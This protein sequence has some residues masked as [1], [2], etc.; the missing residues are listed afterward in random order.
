MTPEAAM[1]LA[2]AQ[3]RRSRGRTHPNPPVGA[4]VYRGDR[5]LGR[6]RTRP[7]GGP[8][9]EVVAIEAALRRHGARALRGASLAV[10]LEPCAHVGRT[11]PCAERVVEAGLGHVLV[12]HVDPYGAVAGRGVALLRR[13]GLEVRLGVLEAECREQHRGFLSVCER[14]RPFVMLK[15][16]SSLDGRI[17][18]SSGASRW[19]SGPQARA[20]V[21]RLRA[22]VDAVLVGSGT[23]L[24]DDPRLTARR[25]GRVV[26]R[27]LRVLV[28][29]R[30]RVPAG[31]RLYRGEAGQSWVLCAPQAPAARRR[32]LEARG[33][34]V[35]VVPVR[36]QGLDLRR[37]LRRLAREGL[38]EV[39]VEGGGGLAAAL[40]RGGLVDELHWFSAPRLIGGDGIPALG[41]LGVRE[42]ARAPRLERLRVRRV[43]DDL[44]WV[45]RLGRGA[46]R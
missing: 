9:A 40:L 36:G 39:L 15:L 31:A 1:R 29:S 35:L 42:L 21:H 37:A 22:G 2:L 10:T 8:H 25:G 44:H 5:V 26:H 45:G 46:S 32:A 34:K 28:D 20:A 12:G 43:G 11:S 41:A 33:V 24:A 38:T 17:A 23:A 16:A 14:G 6:G 27:P 13:A 30:L 7:A 18:T 4:I 3:A 19:I